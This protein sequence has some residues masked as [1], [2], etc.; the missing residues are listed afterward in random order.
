MMNNLAGRNIFQKQ[1]FFTR[2]AKQSAK[3]LQHVLRFFKKRS[4][5]IEIICSLLVILF[6][7]TG[8]NKL[9][10]YETFKVQLTRSPFVQPFADILAIALPVSELAISVLLIVQKKR[11]IGLYLSFL[12]MLLF[13]GYIAAMLYF[14]YYVPCSC[15]GVLAS[16]TWQEHLIFNIAFTLLAL[17]GILLQNKHIAHS[18]KT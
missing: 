16:L 11:L 12:T 10:D 4:L 17:S 9:I 13:T 6:I 8:V 15:G 1:G 18:H 5:Y 2:I 14:S 3:F 7:Y